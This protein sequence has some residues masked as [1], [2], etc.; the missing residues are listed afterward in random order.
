[1]LTFLTLLILLIV[2]SITLF[3]QYQTKQDLAIIFNQLS[4]LNKKISLCDDSIYG[5]HKVS[6]RSIEDGL[7]TLNVKI[8]KVETDLLKNNVVEAII[9]EE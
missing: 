6:L 4:E 8:L 2:I 1:M 9:E 7:R 5:I 3:R